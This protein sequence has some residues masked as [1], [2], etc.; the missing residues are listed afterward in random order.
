[1]ARGDVETR[2]KRKRK[3]RENK[4]HPYQHGGGKRGM[5]ISEDKKK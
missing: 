1:M 5:N 2:N 4:K 3:F